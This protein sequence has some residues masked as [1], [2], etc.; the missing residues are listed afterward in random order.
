MLSSGSANM[1][2]RPEMPGNGERPEMP[3]NG[4]NKPEGAPDGIG[5]FI[6]HDLILL[7]NTAV[8]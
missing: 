6:R 5:V 2:D 8:F 3:M 1:G 4:M 7:I